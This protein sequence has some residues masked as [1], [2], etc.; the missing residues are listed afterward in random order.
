MSKSI[1]LILMYHKIIDEEGIYALPPKRF[2]KQLEIIQKSTK[3]SVITCE[4]ALHNKSGIVITFDDG[5]DDNYTAA[6]ILEEF[7][8][9]GTFFVI[10]NRI[11]QKGFL[12]AQ[13]IK[14]L[15]QRGH[16]IG[17]HT[18]TE[19]FGLDRADYQTALHEWKQGRETIEDIIGSKVNFG[20]VPGG[21][22][23]PKMVQPTYEAG[24][25]HL[26]TSEPILTRWCVNHCWIYGRFTVYSYSPDESIK[27]LVEL[28]KLEIA[29]D[30]FIWNTK[31]TVKKVFRKQYLFF[32]EWY[33]QSR[34]KL[35]K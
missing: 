35:N 30:K 25:E 26:F 34:M 5:T 28:S 2:R 19:Y 22:Y 32:Y 21:Y 27:K 33:K 7:G 3:L 24:V 29:K 8:M 6:S 16:S 31:K 1:Q 18:F 23:S 9:K 10:G 20:S 4:E 11:N 17:T 13:Q 15:Y 14:E 12:T